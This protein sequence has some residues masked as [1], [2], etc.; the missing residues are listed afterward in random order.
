MSGTSNKGIFQ[1][2]ALRAASAAVLIPVA[3]AAVW[4]GGL[5][6]GALALIGGILMGWEWSR[7][8]FEPRHAMK[9]AALMAGA[10]A[11]AAMAGYVGLR[12]FHVVA[13]AAF[14]A[15]CALLAFHHRSGRM[16]WAVLGVP[17][18]SLPIFAAITLRADPA[19]GFACLAWLMVVTWATDTA[20]FFAG[21][22]LGGPKLAPR[23]SPKKTWSG[24]V[25]GTAAAVAGGAAF[26]WALGFPGLISLALVSAVVSVIGQ[27]GDLLVSAFKRAF[28]VKDS[29][30]LIPGHGGVLDRLDSLVTAVVSA[31]AIGA[32]HAGWSSAAQGTLV[33]Q[34]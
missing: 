15:A 2:V 16:L 18:V 6:F 30:A 11:V 33:W 7:I 26:G 4:F 8:A 9:F 22:S 25:A 27:A 19:Y 23:I 5:A 29:S 24:A 20:A 34:W 3:L 21:R 17:Y 13:L 14:W 10:V 31:F 32:F 1:G 28:G 12:P